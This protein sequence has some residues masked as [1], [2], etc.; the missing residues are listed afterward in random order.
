MFNKKKIVGI[1]IDG[2]IANTHERWLSIANQMFGI[3]IQKA[4]I[5][6]YYLDKL[7]KMERETVNEIF[8]KVWHDPD[9]IKLE[10][11]DIPR[12]IGNIRNTF[13]VY[14]LTATIGED[15]E[16]RRWLRTNK[17]SFDGLIH[18]DRSYKKLDEAKKHGISIFIDD[19]PDLA[20][21]A[22]ALDYTTILILQPWNTHMVER[23][24]EKIKIATDW[25]DVEDLLRIK[26]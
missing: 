6:S 11:N 17:I 13:E 2:T 21:K 8:K 14:I 9:S 1:D 4:E 22:A 7:F 12:V 15:A 23:A 5:N 18:V 26:P 16:V 19:H 10:H 20:E 25:S 24:G 3:N